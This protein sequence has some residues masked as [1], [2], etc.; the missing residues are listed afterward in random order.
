MK[1]KME[2]VLK[3]FWGKY[4]IALPAAQSQ[5]LFLLQKES[6]IVARFF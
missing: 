2:E 3:S 6:I 1:Q 5:K 4:E